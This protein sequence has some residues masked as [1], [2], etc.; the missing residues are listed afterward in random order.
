M[1]EKRAVKG[2]VKGADEYGIDREQHGVHIIH[3]KTRSN[4]NL[5]VIIAII[6]KLFA[7]E[8]TPPRMAPRM[9][10]L[11]WKWSSILHTIYNHF[12]VY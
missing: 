11:C 10:V 12:R 1:T 5:S 4:F 2:A 8:R 7:I 6:Q 3:K 9:A